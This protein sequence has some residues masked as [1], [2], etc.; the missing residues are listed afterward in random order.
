MTVGQLRETIERTIEGRISG[1]KKAVGQ[2]Q[3]LLR[4]GSGKLGDLGQVL[5][6]SGQTAQQVQDL[7]GRLD[8]LAETVTQKLNERVESLSEQLEGLRTMVG[9]LRSDRD[10]VGNMANELK[11]A[12]DLVA[13]NVNA[14][15]DRLPAE[16]LRDQLN[17][18]QERLVSWLEKLNVSAEKTQK[19]SQ[20]ALEDRAEVLRRL[21]DLQRERADLGQLRSQLNRVR[22]NLSSSLKELKEELWRSRI[23][24]SFLKGRLDTALGPAETALA[25]IDSILKNLAE[26]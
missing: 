6:A 10:S 8:N 21:E 13:R 5:S 3:G 14:L 12:L 25:E 4:E 1:V 20:R 11:A 17:T 16:D 23:A 15:S 19:E 2:I 18:G 24:R 22:G 9:E 7:S 26:K